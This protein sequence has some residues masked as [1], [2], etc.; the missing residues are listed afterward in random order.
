MVQE[1]GRKRARTLDEWRR[2]EQPL[3]AVGLTAARVVEFKE[4]TRCSFWFARADRLRAFEG[5]TPP[6]LQDLR[7]SHPD[8]LEQRIIGFVDG[9]GGAYAANT[10][11]VS[12][13]WE[14]RLEPDKQG[15]QFSAVKAHL[16]TNT[17]IE[18]V[19]YGARATDAHE[20]RV[21]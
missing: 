16:R 9:H 19:W 4:G 21:T 17:S 1:G 2:M 20:R 6:R 14:D 3:A 12:H 15:V 18:W 11:V 5:T 10:L 8:W 7:K 13:C